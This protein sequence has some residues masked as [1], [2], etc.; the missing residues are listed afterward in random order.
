MKTQTLWQIHYTCFS[1]VTVLYIN[2]TS[3]LTYNLVPVADS[4]SVSVYTQWLYF[5]EINKYP[6]IEV[7]TCRLRNQW[8]ARS[9]FCPGNVKYGR[10]P[11]FWISSW[12][13]LTNY[14]VCRKNQGIVFIGTS[15]FGTSFLIS[16]DWYLICCDRMRGCREIVTFV[17]DGGCFSLL[18]FHRV[19]LLT[20]VLQHVPC[21]YTA[22]VYWEAKNCVFL[23][24]MDPRL[25]FDAW[26]AARNG[27]FFSAHRG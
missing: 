17:G 11:S 21:T 15:I 18:A 3:N 5:Y 9:P 14:E 7:T 10:M 13:I 23:G 4:C 16:F 27:V 24:R 1:F 6:G 2:L 20:H 19:G 25:G 8:K 22:R 12:Y 26:F